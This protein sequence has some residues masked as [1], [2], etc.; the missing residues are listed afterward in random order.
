MKPKKFIISGTIEI[1]GKQILGCDGDIVAYELPDGR[2][3]RLAACL[4]VENKDGS[5]EILHSDKDMSK[6]GFELVE[7]NQINFL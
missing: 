2:E 6:V 5:V 3:V 7:Y 4:E 1:S